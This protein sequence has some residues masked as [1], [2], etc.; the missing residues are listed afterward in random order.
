MPIKCTDVTWSR[1]IIARACTPESTYLEKTPKSCR[2][3]YFFFFFF[4][5]R[6]YNSYLFLL[7][8]FFIII[9]CWYTRYTI[10]SYEVLQQ[11]VYRTRRVKRVEEQRPFTRRGIRSRNYNAN[12][13]NPRWIIRFIPV[14]V[15][16]PTIRV[17][18]VHVKI[19]QAKNC[20][21]NYFTISLCLSSAI[22]ISCS[23]WLRAKTPPLARNQTLDKI[24][25]QT[26]FDKISFYGFFY[27]NI[28]RSDAYRLY[29]VLVGA[30]ILGKLKY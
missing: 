9:F 23:R 10:A 30:R 7:F 14:C 17:Y 4:F 29:I 5:L 24:F 28:K 3:R 2:L 8:F 13:H 16:K 12:K 19:F 21:A 18:V 25:Y 27:F 26:N 1:L 20:P 11:S 15:G 22:N 6:L